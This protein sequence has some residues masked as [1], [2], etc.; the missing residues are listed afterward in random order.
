M[1]T[2]NILRTEYGMCPKCNGNGWVFPTVPSS[3]ITE[4]CNYCNGTKTVILATE[5]K[6]LNGEDTVVRHV[7]NS[8]EFE[9]N[10]GEKLFLCMRDSGYEIKYFGTTFEFKEGKFI[11]HN[12]KE[13]TVVKPPLGII[14]E[15]LWKEDRYHELS[16][17]I[18]RYRE[19]MKQIP[20]E[21]IN[22]KYELEKFLLERLQKRTPEKTDTVVEDKTP[23]VKMGDLET[24]MNGYQAGVYFCQKYGVPEMMP[25]SPEKLY[26][27]Q[28]V[29]AIREEAFYR[30]RDTKPKEPFYEG[31]P[32]GYPYKFETFPDYLQSLPFKATVVVNSPISTKD[33]EVDTSKKSSWVFCRDCENKQLCSFRGRCDKSDTGK[34]EDWDKPNKEQEQ[35]YWDGVEKDNTGKDSKEWQIIRWSYGGG[36]YT[37]ALSVAGLV[38]A[39]INAVKRL[40]DNEVFTVGDTV[41]WD[42]KPIVING[43]EINYGNHSVKSAMMFYNRKGNNCNIFY[44]KKLPNQSPQIVSTNNDDVPCLSLNDIKDEWSVLYGQLFSGAASIEDTQFYKNIHKKVKQKLKQ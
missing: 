21:W 44:A 17:A 19:A 29:D 36:F 1:N 27:Q 8:M 32:E 37:D 40:S 43:F 42:D 13:D 11:E 33:K 12:K 30:A 31:R 34:E 35:F 2:D 7:Y 6:A 24:Y 3:S 18:N 41:L 14:P 26:T 23:T 39:E 4:T 5:T 28:E 15:W 9:T 38:G 16:G 10:A 20:Q 25:Q 22:E